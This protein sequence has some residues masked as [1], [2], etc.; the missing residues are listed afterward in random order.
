M[1]KNFLRQNLNIHFRLLELMPLKMDRMLSPL[2]T[3][4]GDRVFQS[5]MMTV[6][7]FSDGSKMSAFMVRKK[8]GDPLTL[9]TL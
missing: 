1:T 9:A 2:L 8:R 4:G 7:W 3:G 5:F 6:T